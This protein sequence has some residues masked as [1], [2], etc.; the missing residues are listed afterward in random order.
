MN[1]SK[2]DLCVNA[3]R[4][5]KRSLIHELI[6]IRP[7]YFSSS[8]MSSTIVYANFISGGNG[9]GRR[10]TAVRFPGEATDISLLQNVQSD[11]VAHPAVCWVGTGVLSRG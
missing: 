11:P 6:I 3:L 9:D 2:K 5:S 1:G 7:E 10:G 4:Q 8:D